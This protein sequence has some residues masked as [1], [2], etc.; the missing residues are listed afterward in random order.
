LLE[1]VDTIQLATVGKTFRLKFDNPTDRNTL[2]QHILQATDAHVTKTPI[3]AGTYSTHTHTHTHSLSLPPPILY[4]ILI[5]LSRSRPTQRVQHHENQPSLYGAESLGERAW[6]R[7][8]QV[9]SQVIVAC[10][11]STDYSQK[12]CAY[13]RNVRSCIECAACQYTIAYC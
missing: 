13:L 3:F 4:S 8:V 12:G 10:K 1:G 5:N 2:Y 6:K 9:S 7:K 11:W